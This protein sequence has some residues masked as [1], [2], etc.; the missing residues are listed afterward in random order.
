[1]T[2]RQS[3][4]RQVSASVFLLRKQV[5]ETCVQNSSGKSVEEPGFEYQAVRTDSR[6]HAWSLVQG[7]PGSEHSSAS[8]N[9]RA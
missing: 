5:Q 1:M 2:L 7:H 6:A 8:P 9:H 4:V 3:P